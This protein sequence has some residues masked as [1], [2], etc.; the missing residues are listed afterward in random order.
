MPIDILSNVAPRGVR[1]VVSQ[2]RYPRDEYGFK[3]PVAW[4]DDLR[5]VLA[6]PRRPI[7]FDGTERADAIVTYVTEKYAR[8]RVI[9]CA[10][11]ELD[12]DRHANDGCITRLRLVQAL[13]LREL[14]ICAGLLGPI[15]TGHGKT[16]IDLL[17][18]LA[19][20]DH[21]PQLTLSVLLV[22]PGLVSQLI[23]D[24]EYI[25]QHFHMP[26][27]IFH[28][29]SYTN[30][31]RGNGLVPL[32]PGAPVLHV[33]PYSR[34]RMAG[35]TDWLEMHLK[36]HAIIADEVQKLRSLQSAT[37]SRV[38]RYMNAH[39][40]TRFAGWS[41]SITDKSLQDYAHL[42]AWSLRGGS[43]LPLSH[44]IVAEWCRAIDPGENPADPGPL[45]EMCKP[46]E[47]IIDGFRR[48]VVETI[49]V[50]TSS[51]PAVDCGLEI[52]ERKAPPIPPTVAEA[53]TSIRA[54]VRPD[55]E[56]LVDA[57]AMSK[58]AREAACGFY[59]RWIFPHNEFP[60]DTAL[61]MEWLNARKEW[62]KEVREKLHG[63]HEH[64][65]SPLLVQHAAER[66][67]GDRPTVRGLPTWK[68]DTWP[69]WRDVKSK[70]RPETEAVR[71]DPYLAADAAKW[72]TEHRGIVWYE[73]NAFG[74]W[75][76]EISGM[77]MY[78]GGV[79]GGGLLDEHGRIRE[80]G[81]RS[82][83]LSI[84]AHGTGRNGLQYLFSNCIIANPMSTP[85]GWEQT[86]ARLHR[87]GQKADTVRTW[88]YRHTSE[89]QSHVDEALR[90]A[91]YVEGTLGAKQKL[92]IGFGLK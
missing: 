75:V 22:P 41:G 42:A 13:A 47:A 19:L 45:F 31:D 24:Y 11:A 3:A 36:P 9:P 10:C 72:A 2:T 34:L 28:G 7:E 30:M 37:T 68:A 61:V 88:L 27:I 69:R 44:E 56:E 43:P 32:K 50:V 62:H 46:G 66:A 85:T 83:I 55:G 17:A 23:G 25:G 91:A 4:S 64:I 16:A 15:A 67:W 33:V 40:E 38:A 54:Y 80:R 12:P 14:S 5:R 48:R 49:G 26:Q 89:M 59:Y 77:P 35:A 86:L 60:R 58:C 39:P 8:K 57:L 63:R 78:G 52:A 79:A 71:L 90:R 84:R 81:D 76:S 29:N 73:H 53:L 18:P 70:V 82:V 21:D 1:A 87:P 20:V 51:T 65:D 74:Q 92:R 6:L